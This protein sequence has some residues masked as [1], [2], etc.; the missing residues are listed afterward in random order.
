VDNY[1]EE[2][3]AAFASASKNN[4]FH[5]LQ[6]CNTKRVNSFYISELN[7]NDA[8]EVMLLRVIKIHL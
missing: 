8:I 2:S 5:H 6:R 4:D 3:A 7:K 1:V